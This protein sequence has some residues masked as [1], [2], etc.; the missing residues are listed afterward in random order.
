MTIKVLKLDY[1][2]LHDGEFDTLLGSA[3]YP[4]TDPVFN[5][6]GIYLDK[7]RCW[8]EVNGKAYQYDA[9]MFKYEL[10]LLDVERYNVHDLA[11]LRTICATKLATKDQRQLYWDI[12]NMLDARDAYRRGAMLGKRCRKRFRKFKAD[13]GL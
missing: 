2:M 7:D 9:K 10:R 11:A 4:A 12:R 6:N 3:R 13:R 8:C 5:R 1:W